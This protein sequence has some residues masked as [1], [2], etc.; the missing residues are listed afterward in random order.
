[1]SKGQSS[2]DLMSSADFI[3]Y[4]DAGDRNT[5][6]V[7]PETIFV[8]GALF[9]TDVLVLNSLVFRTAPTARR[10]LSVHGF[11]RP[12]YDHVTRRRHRRAG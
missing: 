4:F 2:G 3:C 5:V 11:S 7:N 10:T 6:R 12:V 1:M 9:G 8:A